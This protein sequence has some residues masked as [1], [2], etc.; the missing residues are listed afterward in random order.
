MSL[1]CLRTSV[2]AILLVGGVVALPLSIAHTT[3][4]DI[5]VSDS[6]SWYA[7]F[8]QA[9]AFHSLGHMLTS[10]HTAMSIPLTLIV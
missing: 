3:S 1:S 4:R 9:A 8:Q 6:V 10:A 2:V 5:T 7:V